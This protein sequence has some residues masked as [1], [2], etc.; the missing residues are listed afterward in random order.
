M[1]PTIE[2]YTLFQFLY[3]HFN[4]E[5]FDDNLPSCM[6]VIT[7]K[8]NTFGYYSKERWVNVDEK[9]T[10]EIAINPMFF[11]QYPLIEMLQTLCHEMCHLWQEHFG[12]P[13]RRTYHNAEWGEK[14][15]S[16]GLFPSSTGKEG[17]KETGQQM[18]EYPIENGNFLRVC[19]DLAKNKNFNSLWYD[20]TTTPQLINQSSAV[21]PEEP[22]ELIVS[23]IKESEANLLYTRF[24]NKNPIV[25]IKQTD[26]SK[27]K[28]SCP[29][30]GLN[31]WGKPSLNII[32]GECNASLELLEN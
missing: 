28:Y 8:N 13:S 11:S 15:K 12:T 31:V 27:S 30:C 21:F 9:R 24:E 7:R 10:D 6:I 18:M 26:A 5:L 16:I 19:K 22:H 20:R 3:D 14:M 32:C 1:K 23:N 25:I 29:K 2:F 17:G 4:K